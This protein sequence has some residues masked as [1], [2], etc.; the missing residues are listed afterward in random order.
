[1]VHNPGNAHIE[2][3]IDGLEGQFRSMTEAVFSKMDHLAG[4]VNALAIKVETAKPAEKTSLLAVIG[5]AAALSV[6]IGAIGTLIFFLIDARVGAA[7]NSANRFVGEMTGDGR[8]YVQ[9]AEQAA[10]LKRIEDAMSWKASF[11]ET[12]KP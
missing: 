2:K 8:I 7:T 3:R 4:S 1:M 11:A 5:A 10:R 12:S 9:M 6:V